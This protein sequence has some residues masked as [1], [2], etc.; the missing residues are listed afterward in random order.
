MVLEKEPR[1]PHLDQQA[2]GRRAG[3]WVWLELLNPQSPPPVTHFLLQDHMSSSFQITL[4]LMSLWGP[5]SFKPPEKFLTFPET[6]AITWTNIAQKAFRHQHSQ[7]AKPGP[8]QN[9]EMS[10]KT[11]SGF[12]TSAASATLYLYSEILMF[13]R[14]RIKML[15]LKGS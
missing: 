3:H 15:A 8:R 2:A 6:L 12:P 7:Q 5:L 1:V 9:N 13:E 4:L 14:H 10:H 11:F